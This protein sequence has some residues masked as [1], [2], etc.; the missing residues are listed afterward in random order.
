MA[1]AASSAVN[2]AGRSCPSMPIEK[3]ARVRASASSCPWITADRAWRIEATRFISCKTGPKE[4]TMVAHRGVAVRQR[5][6][7]L[8]CDRAFEQHQRL[9]Y[10]LRHA[11]IDTR[12]GPQNEIT[13]IEAVGPFAFDPVDLS[14]PHARRNRADDR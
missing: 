3:P 6:V 5:I 13:G 4:Q 9:R 14:A 1:S 2:A 7:R 10:L 12:L 8:E 11:G